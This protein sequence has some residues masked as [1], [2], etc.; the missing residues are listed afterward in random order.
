MRISSVKPAPWLAVNLH[1][2]LSDGAAVNTQSRSSLTN[3]AI[4]RSI[5]QMNRIWWWT[6]HCLACQWTT[7]LCFSFHTALIIFTKSMWHQCFRFNQSIFHFF[8]NVTVI[9]NTKNIVKH[10]I[11]MFSFKTWPNLCLGHK[12]HCWHH[13]QY[14]CFHRRKAEASEQS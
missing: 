4:S 11:W 1:H 10:L 12:P 13:C 9:V 6:W 3:S 8:L 14:F 7:A 5:S 2:L